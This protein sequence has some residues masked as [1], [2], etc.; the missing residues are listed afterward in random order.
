MPQ[1]PPSFGEGMTLP[2]FFGSSCPTKSQ[3]TLT[4]PVALPAPLL[5]AFLMT[6]SANLHSKNPMVP[7][8]SS[9]ANWLYFAGEP[10]WLSN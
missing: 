4:H 6:A 8:N 2:G 10:E 1:G 9:G 5:S 3:L 7:Q